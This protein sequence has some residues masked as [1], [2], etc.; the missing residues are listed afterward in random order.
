[1][2]VHRKWRSP[3]LFERVATVIS[4]GPQRLTRGNEAQWIVAVRWDTLKL[5]ASGTSF[6]SGSTRPMESGF[7]AKRKSARSPGLDTYP[8]ANAAAAGTAE[9]PVCPMKR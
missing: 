6:A 4:C 1:M 5:A 8:G 7:S 2:S 3:T 9:C